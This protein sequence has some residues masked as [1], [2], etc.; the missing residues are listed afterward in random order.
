MGPTVG[1]LRVEGRRLL[2]RGLHHLAVQLGGRGLV[3]AGGVV[4]PAGAHRVQ[5]SHHPQR[6][7]LRR[8]LGQVERHL[9]AAQWCQGAREWPTRQRTAVSVCRKA[10]WVTHTMA[11]LVK[12]RDSTISFSETEEC[13]N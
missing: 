8:V 10:N 3:D 4:Q 13:Q 11:T 12:K 2:L 9:A 6:V 1:R 5:Q 7:H